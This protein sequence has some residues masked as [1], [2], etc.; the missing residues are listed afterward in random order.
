MAKT[1]GTKW[2]LDEVELRHGVRYPTPTSPYVF[3]DSLTTSIYPSHRRAG[4][5]AQTMLNDYNL[6]IKSESK[7]F[8]QALDFLKN[9]AEHERNMEIDFINEKINKL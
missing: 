3:L 7:N 9:M 6:Y 5:R 2:I 4:Q 1:M 8:N